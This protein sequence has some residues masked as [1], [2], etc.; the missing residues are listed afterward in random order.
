[1]IRGDIHAAEQVELHY[2]GRVHGNIFSPSLF[3]DKGVIFE[4]ECRM[5]PGQEAPV[6][7]SSE[8]V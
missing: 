5:D 6:P 8:E 2:P 4:G 3:I 1:V 7:S